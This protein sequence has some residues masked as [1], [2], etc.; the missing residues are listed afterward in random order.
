M[1]YL[2]VII[3]P[4]SRQNIYVDFCLKNAINKSMFFSDFTT[5][6]IFRFTFQ[7]LRVAQSCFWVFIKLANESQRFFVSLWLK[8]QQV[9]QVCLCLFLDDNLISAHKLRIYWSSSS[10]LVKLLPGCFSA[11][12]I[13]AKKSSFVIKVVSSFSATS[14][15]RYLAARFSR[16]SSSAMI[17]MLRR[18]SA[19]IC[20]A[21]ITSFFGFCVQR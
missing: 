8:A 2:F 16:F 3:M 1:N 14:L 9:L 17:L 10:T 12:S 20:T 18:I 7:W 6:S 4:I 19:F 11:R 15:R 5:P 21:V 13:L